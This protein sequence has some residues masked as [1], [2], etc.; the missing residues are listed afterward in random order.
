LVRLGC[1]AIAVAAYGCEDPA[2]SQTHAQTPAD[3]V[4]SAPDASSADM[5]QSGLGETAATDKEVEAV[6]ASFEAQNEHDATRV[7]AFYAKDAVVKA[8]GLPD[9]NGRDVIATEEAKA[10]E[11]LP[12]GKWGARRILIKDDVAIVEWTST[13]TAAP[14]KKNPTAKRFGANGVSIMWFGT[15]GLI[16]EEHDV[17]N[18]PT[19]IAQT[20]SPK[21]KVRE[22]LWQPS[23]SADVRIAKA[24]PEEGKNVETSKALDKAFESHDEKAFTDATTE[25]LA[26]DDYAA[27]APLIGRADVL[28][29]FQAVTTAL[30]DMKITCQVWAVEDM[31]AKECTR[32]ATHE[33][34]LPLGSLK[35]PATHKLIESH[36]IDI[37]QI[38]RGKVSKG[39]SYADNLEMATQL[40]L[41]SKPDGAAKKK[42]K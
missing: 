33:G 15:D 38:K 2:T 11:E 20:G 6:K 3:G 24:T 26:W 4:D 10:F 36:F 34:T 7:A 16:K 17:L 8:P 1:I 42:K 41:L 13:G 12:D 25:D 37:L 21:G 32:K 19:V 22:V 28:K 23:G 30:P 9:W 35:I 31:V 14:T 5:L 18:A 27:P 29:M 39:W 40:G